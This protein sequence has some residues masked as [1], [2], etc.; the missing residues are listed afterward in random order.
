MRLSQGQHQQFSLPMQR[1]LRLLRMSN[2]DLGAEISAEIS[3]NP[4]LDAAPPSASVIEGRARGGVA[5]GDRA[6]PSRIAALDGVGAEPEARAETL[7]EHL[8]AQIALAHL[9][10]SETFLAQ[11]LIG[12]I[13]GDGYLRVDLHALADRLGAKVSTLEQ[14]LKVL[15]G[16]DPVGVFARD[17][18]ECLALQLAERGR[19]DPLM[20]ALLDRL[21]LVASGERVKLQATLGCE[22]E[23]LDDMLSELRDLAPRPGV[24]FGFEPAPMII[25]EVSVSR[26]ADGG[27]AVE[28]WAPHLPRLVVRA[29]RFERLASQCRRQEDVRYLK[30][31]LSAARRFTDLL[32]RRGR[33]ILEVAGEI[34]KRQEAFLI[35]GMAGLKPLT[36]NVIADSLGVHESTV[37]R[38][39]ANKA[40]LTPRGVLPFKAFFAAPATTNDGSDAT[41]DQVTARIA[42]LIAGEAK[43]GL[44]LSD[45]AIAER[46]ATGGIKISRRTVARRRECMGFLG[47]A[48]RKSQLSMGAES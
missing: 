14:V 46:L 26:M 45:E 20:A 42:A 30:E 11:A 16:F 27:W 13:D 25:P 33:T 29:D 37:S 3:A 39:V 32:A 24:A 44:I 41:Q 2:L 1:A 38:V 15:Q 6:Q 40:M 7:V 8:F 10:P 5:A 4:L 43:A 17:V 48:Q 34:V 23:D 35:E 12:E 36:L 21:D 47:A 18:P 31:R 28:S 9:G 22:R 19:L